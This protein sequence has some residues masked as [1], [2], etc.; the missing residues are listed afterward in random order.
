MATAETGKGQCIKCGKKKSAVRC[1]G[2]QELFCFDHLTDHQQELSIQFDEIEMNRDLLRQT[3]TEQINNPNTS[4]LIKQINQWEEES[5]QRIK[6]T[7]DECRQKLLQHTTTHFHQME[8]NLVK[9]TD[10]IRHTR[11]ENDFNEID[12]RLLKERLTQLSEEISKPSY[13]SIEQNP[14]PFI[15]GMTVNIFRN[16]F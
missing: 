10:Q 2:C 11:Q 16:K 14:A 1:E 12:L 4:L 3:L 15:N 13:L 8:V 6:Q 9:L 5:I 7:A